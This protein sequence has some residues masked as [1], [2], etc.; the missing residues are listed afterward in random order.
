MAIPILG[1]DVS[2]ETLDVHLL[3]KEQGRHAVFSNDGVGHRK[4]V[5]WLKKRC[6]DV[7]AHVCMEATGMYAFPVAESLYQ[8]KHCVSMVNPARISAYAKSQLA[9][10]K[11]DKLDAALIADFCHTQNPS[12]WL[13]PRQEVRE[14]QALVRLL[15][16]LKSIRQAENNRFNSGIRS[17]SVAHLLQ[18]HINYLNEKIAH[19]E[20]I[21]LD[22][23]QQDADLSRKKNLLTS[24][25]GIGEQ[26][27]HVILA[28]LLY[29]D[30]FEQAKQVA[31]FA[32]LN[33]KQRLS[34]KM[35]GH[36]PISKMGS[37]LLR[38][39]LYFPA[40]VAKHHNPIIREFCNNL[41]NNGKVPMEVTIASMRKLLHIAFGVLKNDCPF[42]PKHQL[43]HRN[44]QLALTCTP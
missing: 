12:E 5:R 33:P 42:D 23:I 8:A 15:D 44:V 2:K 7:S 16:D 13:P 31:A 14:L 22:H 1:I 17:C 3:I 21:I 19:V 26:T 38:K 24:I 39:A 25:P 35:K 28:E 6:G 43:N 10:N 29:L 9:R 36:S 30:S 34:G 18:D 4:L 41:E 20:Q 11:T 27:A 40:I 37:S 32:G